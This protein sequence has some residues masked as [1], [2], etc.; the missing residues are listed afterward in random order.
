MNTPDS[1][2]SSHIQPLG[3][4]V[5]NPAYP[6][7]PGGNI[8]DLNL[9]GWPQS[10][11]SIQVMPDPGK[12]MPVE[13]PLVGD[14][15]CAGYEPSNPSPS[16][17]NLA[18]VNG[19]SPSPASLM[20]DG[21]MFPGGYGTHT[22]IQPDYGVPSSNQP[23]L[24]SMSVEPAVSLD[25][26]AEFQP[27]PMHPDLTAYNRPYGLDFHNTGGVSDLFKPD[28]VLQD[29]TNP[30][31]PNG[32]SPVIRNLDQPDPDVPD[33]QNPQLTPDVHMTTR[34]GDLDPSALS[35]MH[36]DPTVQSTVPYPQSHMDGSVATMNN[37]RRRH[38]DLLTSGL[39]ER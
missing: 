39:E 2:E 26:A 32:I 7:P 35:T 14:P 8:P 11:S 3:N 21:G 31:I 24:Q 30:D 29:L 4:S 9:A 34:P 37:R 27:D 22:I 33:L 25:V 28:P 12:P 20:P 23:S 5:P 38:F 19:W 17:P 16:A 18:G 13:Y 15:T 36:Q 1:T 10:G 6:S